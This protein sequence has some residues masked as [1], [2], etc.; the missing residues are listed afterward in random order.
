MSS[1]S[2]NHFLAFDLGAESG[3]A[4]LGTLEG[5]R[6]VTRELHR[7]PN[8]P[9]SLFGH[10]HWNV[11]DLFAE[12]KK[13]VRGCVGPVGIVPDSLAVD[14]WG[15][16]FGLLNR[17]GTLLGLPFAYRD[18]RNVWGMK[19]FL[20]V[21]SKEKIYEIT[22]IQFLPFNTLFQIHA[23]S[24]EN[25]GLLESASDLLFMP[26]LLTYF[27]TGRRT[28][29]A[30]IASTSQLLDPR[31]RTW[32]TDL[33][34]ALGIEP[35]FLKTLTPSG[36]VVGRLLDDVS[37]ETGCPSLPVVATAGHDTASAVAAVPAEGD[38]WAFLS[39][40][41]WSLMGIETP[42][43][44]ISPKTLAM[45]FTNEGGMTGTIRFLKN[46]T[47]LWLVQQCRKRWGGPESLSYEDLTDAAAEAPAFA[48]MIDPD[49][50]SFLNPPDMPEA[51]LN[52]CRRTNQR[53]PDSNAAIVRCIL[54]S[55]A[56]K[57]RIVLD[58]LRSVSPRPI[59]KIHIIGGGSNNA[60]L[61]QFTADA[62]SLPVIAGPAEATAVGNI[63]GQA[64]ALGA[65][66]SLRDIRVIAAS[67]S[68]L[69]IYEPRGTSSWD[70]AYERYWPT[71]MI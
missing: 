28:N 35:T 10:L 45:N 64:L 41:T 4:I 50:P 52:F 17:E 40:G 36:T 7:F 31:T 57:Y 1:M 22:G 67:L 69:R 55:L 61:C 38:D 62:T 48:A 49:D 53:L 37:L 12:M 39:S 70:K 58:E 29:E 16:D 6:L 68:E 26:D 14:T 56:M 34:A 71:I 3:R 21:V 24:L 9:M 25:P 46:V 19:K 42:E 44:I 51:I 47:G 13:A 33:L 15:V 5:E 23:Q 60:L 2:R 20:G 8:G 27:L 66:R 59:R 43:P 30:T 65:V 11:Y 63:L 54:E 18:R 32:S